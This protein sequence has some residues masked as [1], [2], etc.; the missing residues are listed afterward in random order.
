MARKFHLI[1]YHMLPVTHHSMVTWK[2]PR[3]M[4]GDRYRFD[5]PEIW[6]YVARLCEQAKFDAVFTADVEGIY[7][8]WQNSYRGAVRY[9]AQVPCFEP[10]VIMT[11][12]AAA[13]KYIGIAVTLTTNSYPPYVAARKFA[14][15]DHLTYGRAAW[16]V[17]TAFHHA[18]FQNLGYDDI[19]IRTERYDRA[20]EYME[21]CYRLWE[22]W[23]EDAIV[24]DVERDMFADPS[25]VHEINFEGKWLLD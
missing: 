5:R 11:F 21:V 10:T 23:D 22:S 3:N 24:M 17:V 1:Q 15:L 14:T 13:T 2:H 4:M 20:D 9:G 6:Q 18:A 7:A 19:R 25:K 12:M 8:E 16:N